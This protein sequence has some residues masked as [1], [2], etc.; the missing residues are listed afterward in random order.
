MTLTAPTKD[1]IL[2]DDI[3]YKRITKLLESDRADP[4][5]WQITRNTTDKK[6]K[7]YA[8]KTIGGRKGKKWR[9]HRLIA[10]L[11][12]CDIEDM[13]IDHINGD[14]LD[15]RWENLRLVNSTQNKHNSSIR[16]DNTSG[17]K[18][19]TWHKQNQCWVAQIHVNGKHLS[20]GAHDTPLEAAKA[21]NQ[22]AID[23]FGIY[24]QLNKL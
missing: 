15:N 9:M 6:P 24:A 12:K 14:T 1:K 8:T 10:L 22:A 19:V 4:S 11:R 5:K 13:E 18:G 7:P 21:Y 3:D 23:H 16:S 2:L 17:Y 20:L